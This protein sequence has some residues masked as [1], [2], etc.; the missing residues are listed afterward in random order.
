MNI[1]KIESIADKMT[2]VAMTE[3]YGSE[4]TECEDITEHEGMSK[5]WDEL[6]EE[7]FALLVAIL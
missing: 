2:S 4:F 3:I 5:M 1:D 6:N 7:C